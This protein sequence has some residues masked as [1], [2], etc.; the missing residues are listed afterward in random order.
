MEWKTDRSRE[1]Y[2]EAKRHIVGGVNSPS[3]AFGAV[4]RPYPIVIDR[5]QDAYLWDV[6]GNHYIDYLCAYGAM[7][8]GHAHPHIVEAVQ[9]AAA[10]G[11]VY[12]TLTELE[13]ALAIRLKEAL[14]FVD[15]FRFNVSGTEAVM[16]AIRVA[17]GY[18]GRDKLLKFDGCYHGHSDPM[19]VAAGSGTS[20]LGIDESVGVPKGITQDVISIPYNDVE[21]FTRVIE[22]QGDQIAAVLVEP[23]VG[24][25]GIVTPAPGFLET[26]SRLA[27]E[28]G[29]L[30]IWDEVVTAFRFRPGSVQAYFD[31]TPDI[32]VLGKL[33]G[34]GLPIGAYGGR[35]EI[36][37]V[38]A[39]VGRVYQA[40]T[41][42]GNPVSTAAG[43]AFL[44]VI[45]SDPTLYE[46]TARYAK[47]LADTIE[48]AGK[49]HGIP[50]TVGLFGGALSPYFTDQPV[51]DFAGC[52]A[53]DSARFA[54]FFGYML[55]QGICFAPSKFEA[56]FVSA[57]HSES[58]IDYT[59][60]AIERAFARM[61]REKPPVLDS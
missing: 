44:E 54:Q 52:V 11:T 39:P 18:T 53:S 9:R 15:L 28:A 8:L 6:D 55:E 26:I 2:A 46:R 12:G 36:M 48:D 7:L 19:L 47:I 5:G 13:I 49:R 58:D 61:A 21:T 27:K 34:G 45:E 59:I 33:I 1:L 57:A 24:N 38:V 30:T 56:L 37:E 16:S 20:T 17:R 22:E 43:L 14:P 4:G 50:V 3:R 31:C 60:E 23:I 29:A 42:A 40:G 35:A 32:V 51:T 41:L 10:R 25:F